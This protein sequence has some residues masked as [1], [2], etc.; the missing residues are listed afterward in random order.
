[1]D[2]SIAWYGSVH[3]QI[4]HLSVLVLEILRQSVENAIGQPSKSENSKLHAKVN[5][6]K[7]S[8]LINNWIGGTTS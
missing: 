8:M 2:R 1:M 5:I 3:D 7:N 4:K 6:L